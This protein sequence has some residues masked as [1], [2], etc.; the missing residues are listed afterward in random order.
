MCPSSWPCCLEGERSDRGFN[1]LPRYY[2][3]RFPAP[4]YDLRLCSLGGSGRVLGRQLLVN[5]ELEREELVEVPSCSPSVSRNLT[6]SRDGT[7]FVAGLC[8]MGRRRASSRIRS[9]SPPSYFA[10]IAANG[11]ASNTTR[12]SEIL[13]PLIRNHSEMNDVPAGVF[14]IIS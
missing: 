13:S 7:V 10:N 2:A 12:I 6:I 11:L 8:P 3:P 4:T 5:E 1:S 14:V 9:P